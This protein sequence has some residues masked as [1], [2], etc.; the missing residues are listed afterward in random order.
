[1]S[2]NDKEK[3]EADV[4]QALH[5]WHDVNC[6]ETPLSY[7]LS[8][9]RK[10][11]EG[12][13]NIHQATNEVLHE[14][15]K[16]LETE[17]EKGA[18]VLRLRFLDE[19]IVR[20]V[21]RKFDVEEPTMYRWQKLAIERLA[22]IVQGQE[23]LLRDQQWATL[24]S[25]LEPLTYDQLIGVEDYLSQLLN[26]LN[27]PES[28][29]LIAIEG[30]GGLG[31]TSLADALSRRVINEGLFD[32]F[33]WISAKQ[34]TFN[35]G[36]GIRPVA[37]SS[38]TEADLVEKLVAQLMLD[39]PRPDSLLTQEARALLRSRLKQSRHL[40][41]IDNLETVTDIES[42]LPTLRDL[43]NPSKFLLTSR[44]RLP[45]ESGVFHF[46]LPELTE[47]NAL[48][49]VRHE[50][51][52]HGLSDLAQAG[53]EALKQIFEIVGGNPLALRLVV[54]QAHIHGLKTILSDLI[55]A[56]GE[57][58]ETL[59]AFLYRR[60]WDHMDEAARQV[61]LAMLLVPE[62]GGSLEY[63]AN[64]TG[65]DLAEVVNALNNL[66][67]RNLVDSIGDLTERCYTIHHLTRT[68]LHGLIGWLVPS[69]SSLTDYLAIFRDHILRSI[70]YR[71][72]NIQR[73]EGLLSP[74]E[75]AHAL[76][77]L[78]YAFKLPEAWPTTR[79]VLLA[80]APKM[81]Q[82]GQHGEW[83]TYLKQ[84]IHQSQTLDD[85]E[86]MAE[87][88]FQLGI[89]YELQGN[90]DQARSQFEASEARSA[91]LKARA[92]NRLGYVARRCR[93]FEE[94][95][96]FIGKALDLLEEHDIERAYS[97][98]VLGTIALDKRAWEEAVK[99]FQ[100]SLDLWKQ[101]NNRRMMA[102]SLS[103]LGA[104]W[105]PLTKYQEAIEV[106]Q[107][108]TTLFEEIGDPIN[109]AVAQMNLGNVYLD[110]QKPDE[111]LK[112]FGTAERVF[113]QAQEPL[114]LAKV[115][116]NIGEAYRQMQQWAKAMETF[117]L[118]IEH[119]QKIGNFV[120]LVNALDG[121]G[122]VY[123]SQGEFSK[124]ESTFKRALNELAQFKHDPRYEDLYEMLIKHLQEAATG[125]S[126][127]A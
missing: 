93:Q 11:R 75:Q 124:A 9:K 96:Q 53:D 51:N 54:G 80:M 36:R 72:A 27:S 110:L 48:R 126:G 13:S 23:N 19:M 64:I 90:Y 67:R 30:L 68:F 35:L 86:T 37:T 46:H 69:S 41:V 38:M 83:I 91:N 24:A 28:P 34:L 120:S 95:T 114:R 88:H 99:H 127:V 76:H 26:L 31:K 82:A 8:V 62:H 122:L 111:S 112:L 66:V 113:R 17:A 63:L 5:L 3:L 10:L 119:C 4:H 70:E 116:N 29:W 25:R 78:N 115:Y 94:A 57:K 39:V 74:D 45:Y 77:S 47:D 85:H 117:E 118:S 101:A 18:K 98:L 20:E 65:L 79:A 87:L 104:A 121:L 49:L 43:A 56:R 89:L 50:A 97:Y 102:L 44:E 52:L 107:Q 123:L 59:Y 81:E 103:N 73:S 32:D 15:L 58:V 84:G 21:A 105:R 60:A 42:L 106:Y 71:V 33:G 55:A 7:L 14:A 40:I 6:D 108:A 109:Q 125:E 100:Q 16:V 22:K 1:M 2:R 12:A 61:W 92:L